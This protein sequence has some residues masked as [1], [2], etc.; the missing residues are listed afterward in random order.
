MNAF[1]K[2]VRP[3]LVAILIA[4]PVTLGI[5]WRHQTDQRRAK[6]NSVC[7]VLVD[8]HNDFEN[9]K[10]YVSLFAKDQKGKNFVAGL[11][12]PPKPNC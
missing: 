11:P 6:L 2:W 10:N 5:V 12:V 1:F 7:A 9:L 3:V 8:T 4:T